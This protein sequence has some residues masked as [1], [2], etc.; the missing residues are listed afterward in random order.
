MKTEADY[1]FPLSPD[2][3]LLERD[4]PLDCRLLG[5]IIRRYHAGA[6]SGLDRQ[7]G[8]TEDRFSS[9]WA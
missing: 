5:S 7:P 4:V 6:R 8:R 9:I 2:V 3:I 1:L